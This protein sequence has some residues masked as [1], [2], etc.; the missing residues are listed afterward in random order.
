ML[1]N[2]IA[3]GFA[4][5]FLAAAVGQ[6][7]GDAE[8]GPGRRA[9]QAQGFPGGGKTRTAPLSLTYANPHIILPRPV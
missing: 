8:E 2:E 1:D 6:G 7:R 3:G 5:E 9:E 4:G